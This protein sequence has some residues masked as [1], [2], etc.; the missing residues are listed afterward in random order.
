MIDKTAPLYSEVEKILSEE[1]TAVSFNWTLEF[2]VKDTYTEEFRL[3]DRD[4]E[5]LSKDELEE[6][7]FKP[8]KITNIDFKNDY[9]KSIMRESWARVV[10]PFGMW[11]KCIYPAREHLLCIVRRLALVNTTFAIDEE[12]DIEEF[13]FDVLLHTDE[14]NSLSGI[15]HNTTSRTDLDNNYQPCT[16]DLE[17]LERS[18]EKVRKVTVGGIY[19]NVTPEDLIKN[20]LNKFTEDLEIEGEPAI[21]V[22]S[23]VEAHNSDKREHILIPQGMPLLDVPNYIQDNCGGV[24]NTSLNCYC[25][26]DKIFVYPIY[27][28][29]RFEE[30]KKT[31]TVLRVT[32]SVFP[33][34][35]KTYRLDGDALFV[36]GLSDALFKDISLPKK[37]SQGNGVRS[38]DSR[39]YLNGF[40]E[41]KDNK[42]VAKRKE[43]NNEFKAADLGEQDVV[44]MSPNKIN[45]NPFNERSALAVRSGGTYTFQ[46]PN[47]K[48]ELLYPGMPARILYED[49][50]EIME[51][52]GVVLGDQT[53]VALIGS[54]LTANKHGTSTVINLFAL[55]YEEKDS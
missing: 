31:L 2:K 12:E 50:G 15:D 7:I 49:N 45:S 55:P 23:V 20:V 36:L 16:V 52:R 8:M 54:G 34:L 25:A 1:N 27:Q 40:V 29:D 44:Y 37:L 46:W 42:T 32:K 26:E 28:T 4:K 21:N 6:K 33:Q 30:E 19:R 43:L 13:I 48:P 17:L 5:Y 53:A 11:A 9:E 18:V 39:K 38:S 47:S 24:Y 51:L 35:E 10:I 14:T 3:T 22:I 41:T